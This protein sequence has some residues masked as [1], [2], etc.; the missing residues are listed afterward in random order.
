MQRFSGDQSRRHA[1]G[2]GWP[3]SRTPAARTIASRAALETPEKSCL[4]RSA[5]FF[6][7]CVAILCFIVPAVA[8]WIG[9]ESLD[10]SPRPSEWYS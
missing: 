5:M 1:V 3:Y 6:A 9:I 10:R 4:R 8:V 7:A 2:Y